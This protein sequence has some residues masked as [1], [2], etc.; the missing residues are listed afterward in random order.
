MQIT[1]A[2]PKLKL[3]LAQGGREKEGASFRRPAQTGTSSAD[4]AERIG[5]TPGTP[6]VRIRS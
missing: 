5:L 1:S 4:L 3:G 2:S 6:T